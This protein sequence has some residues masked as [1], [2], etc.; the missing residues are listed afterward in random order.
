[1]LDKDIRPELLRQ[2]VGPDFVF[3]GRKIERH[4]PA[5]IRNIV[6]PQVTAGRREEIR[7]QPFTRLDIAGIIAVDRDHH[8]LVRDLQVDPRIRGHAG[9]VGPE[10]VAQ[11]VRPDLVAAGRHGIPGL[12]QGIGGDGLAQIGPT[13][14]EQIGLDAFHGQVHAFG[15]VQGQNTTTAVDTQ[16]GAAV[17]N[18]HG[19]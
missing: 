14:R 7:F 1:M 4:L 9:D 12:A 18:G 19:L 8:V 6:D 10:L 11:V 3:L 15:Q 16:R 2:I 5:G 13:R 17:E